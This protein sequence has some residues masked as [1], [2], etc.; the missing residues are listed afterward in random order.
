MKLRVLCCSI[1]LAFTGCANWREALPHSHAQ[2]PANYV[3]SGTWARMCGE[4]AGD[5][6]VEAH[7]GTYY[8]HHVMKVSGTPMHPRVEYTWGTAIPPKVHAH[9]VGPN[10]LAVRFPHSEAELDFTGGGY[11]LTW[12]RE[13]G[14]TG[15]GFLRRGAK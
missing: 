8:G 9:V 4:F 6:T 11:R 1:L 7:G 5:V 2:D 15:T 13:G 14:S 3:A 10:R 12:H